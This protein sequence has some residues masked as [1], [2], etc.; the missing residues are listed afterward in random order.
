MKCSHSV[1]NHL[2]T[3][4]ELL[5]VIAIIAILAAMLLPALGNARA[6]ARQT[7][8]SANLKQIGLGLLMYAEDYGD[9][10]PFHGGNGSPW[11][12]KL[13]DYAGEGKKEWTDFA[14][15]GKSSRKTVF[16]CAAAA[17]KLKDRL[18]T[19]LDDSNGLGS[20]YTMNRDIFGGGS[21]WGDAVN[22]SNPPLLTTQ[23]KN[24]SGS[25][26]NFEYGGQ[27]HDSSGG[28]PGPMITSVNMFRG[29]DT[30]YSGGHWHT[31]YCNILFADAHVQPAKEPANGTELGG[32]RWGY[33]VGNSGSVRLWE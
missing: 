28:Y 2:F 8:C 19:R 11:F 29:G 7:S 22:L 17:S 32:I 6:K 14:G 18:E 26:T 4:I 1:E 25:F 27:T 3:L 23:L 21:G 12:K 33:K 31:G 13:S 5:V 30:Y 20:T 16:I 10:F 15:T 9:H 24:P